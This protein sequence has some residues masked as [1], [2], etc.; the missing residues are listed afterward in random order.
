MWTRQCNGRC[1]AYAKRFA[2]NRA[3]SASKIQ[4]DTLNKQKNETEWFA[5]SRTGE[6]IFSDSTEF[7]ARE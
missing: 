6:V 5:A 7:P 4:A 1:N 2:T 3:W